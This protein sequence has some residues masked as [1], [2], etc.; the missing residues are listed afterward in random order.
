M[1]PVNTKPVIKRKKAFSIQEAVTPENIQ[2]HKYYKPRIS[3]TQQIKK[4]F[5]PMPTIIGVFVVFTRYG[6]TT[7]LYWEM[8]YMLPVL[9][10][11]FTEGK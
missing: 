7:V 6:A 3:V 4:H 10:V 5:A 2:G 11:S 8:Y 1:Y 9:R